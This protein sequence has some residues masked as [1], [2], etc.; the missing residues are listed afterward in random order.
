MTIYAYGIIRLK[1]HNA[2]CDYSDCCYA[3]C[4]DALIHYLTMLW[5]YSQRFIIFLTY[6]F[7][8]W[9]AMGLLGYIHQLTDVDI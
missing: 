1:V 8:N 5:P 4:H 9:V 6:H 3:E 2:E 7:I